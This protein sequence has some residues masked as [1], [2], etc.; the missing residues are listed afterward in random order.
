M[1]DS[2]LFALL[3]NTADAAFAVTD[4]GEIRSW[5]RAAERMLGFTASEIVGQHAGDALH[6]PALAG[7]RDEHA[8]PTIDVQLRTR[9]GAKLWTSVSTI[10][11]R[12]ARTGRRL[13]VRLARD[14][15]QRRLNEELL[16]RL[17]EARQHVSLRDAAHDPRVDAL[18]TQER[19]ILRL[20][21]TGVSSP[22]IAASLGISA[23]TLRNHVHHIN[24][25]LRTHT[26]LE[27][28]THAQRR[29]LIA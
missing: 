23:Q 18:S 26:R 3:E 12:D 22:T 28:V 10:V 4:D 25:K 1:L 27:A 7:D 6:A 24:R 8:P 13:I 21:A 19:R 9:S 11:H 15:E 20:L 5:N 2:D 17:L 14:I 29:G 16:A